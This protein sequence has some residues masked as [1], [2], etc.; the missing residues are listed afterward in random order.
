VQ[1]DLSELLRGEKKESEKEKNQRER[2]GKRLKTKRETRLVKTSYKDC[3]ERF[4]FAY[5]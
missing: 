5:S 4:D 3:T 2:K 1:K